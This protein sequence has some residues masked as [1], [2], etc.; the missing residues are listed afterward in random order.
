MKNPRFK[1]NLSLA[2]CRVIPMLAVLAAGCWWNIS[3]A[4]ASNLE[5]EYG[6][7]LGG[8]NID[9]GRGIAVDSEGCVHI[10]GITLSDDFP[11]RD[12]YQT[13][14]GG[15]AGG[16][17]DV[18]VTKFS[19]TGS[20]IIYSTYLG[21]SK[22]EESGGIV[23]DSFGYVYVS[24][25]T[26][27]YNFPTENPY[28]ASLAGVLDVF[29]SKLTS[30]GTGL[31]YST[32]VGGSKNND[33]AYDIAVDDEC[34][35]YVTGSTV[36]SDFPT[37]NS[38]QASHSGS[39]DAFLC[40][41]TTSGS[42]LVYST[43][44]GASIY[45]IAYGLAVDS[46]SHAYLAGATTSPDF[47]TINSYQARFE[48]GTDTK[49]AFVT[50][51]SSAGS[52]LVYST[53]LGGLSGEEEGHDIEVDESGCAYVTGRSDSSDFPT[54][55]PYQSSLS[56]GY[57]A[58][59]TKFMSSGSNLIYS[60]YLGGSANENGYIGG[61]GC[62]ALDAE[63]SVYISGD[64][65]S[66]NFPTVNA[67][68]GAYGG[69]GLSYGD[70]FIGKLSSSGSLL[71]YGSYLG[72]SSDDCGSGVAV[73]ENNVVHIVGLTQSGD[74]PTRNSYQPGLAGS[75]DSFLV[76]LSFFTPSP[77][78]TSTATPPPT[79]SPTQTPTPSPSLTPTPTPG[80]YKTPPPTPSITP[81]P[82]GYKT[83]PPTMTP[84]STPAPTSTP[85]P[86]I[87]PTSTPSPINTPSP[88]PSPSPSPTATSSP[89]PLSTPHSL[90]P[91]LDFNGDGTSDI[92]IFRES[93][94][95]WA[96]RGSYRAY[97]GS[98]GDSLA[99][100]DYNGDGTSEIAIFRPHSGLWA[101][102]GFTR[103]YFGASIDE[104][105]SGDYDGDGSSDQ[106]IYR[107]VSGLW[108]L[109][110]I[111]RIYFGGGN[112]EP[113]PGY[114]DEGGTALVGIYRP[115]SG[116][117]AL[118]GLT[119]LYFGGSDDQAVPGDYDGDGKWNPGI[120]RSASGLW[121]IRRVTRAYYGHSP[122]H[123]VQGDYDGT[124]TDGIAIFRA[125]SGLW[126]IK[127]ITRLYY[128]SGG[129]IPVAR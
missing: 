127:G 50:K 43:Y 21:G 99:P 24:G 76:A 15:D 122:D 26:D 88:S 113:V 6:T 7:Y 93:S 27:S 114:Y 73:N 51:F 86:T 97:F 4:W 109:K 25:A 83:P 68:Q 118:R 98:A 40:K 102:R 112:D 105:V 80:G 28:Q 66:S 54:L 108:A 123:P 106:A 89:T 47:P 74:F 46:G 49:S 100:G 62:I 59:V 124:G 103:N 70:A 92:A 128:G 96:I 3:I 18:F 63:D 44:L 77:T 78:A 30:T 22:G 31:V 38:Y 82:E 5:M 110:G 17:G 52:S 91:I 69:G 101:I 39:N 67:F 81:T 116:M 119:R 35:A 56:G 9:K 90:L 42:D 13:I 75:Y 104:P 60:T 117:W 11:I 121:A 115:A 72:G 111:T 23:L 87:T 84:S 10:T 14:Y 107:S 32:Y 71:R 12:A 95:L 58:F 29:I 85:P 16:W 48:E 94:G 2:I 65:K 129:D 8:S 57:D 55:N 1:P 33:I 120:Y 37:R 61:R 45:D 79:P 20:S 53:Y 64:T 36:S 126:A 34:S 19:S 125:S 41:L